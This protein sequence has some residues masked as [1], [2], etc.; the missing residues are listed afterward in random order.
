M[1]IAKS[2]RQR[3]DGTQSRRVAFLCAIKKMLQSEG[4][5]NY[6]SDIS[7]LIRINFWRRFLGNDLLRKFFGSTGYYGNSELILRYGLSSA[8]VFPKMKIIRGIEQDTELCDIEGILVPIPTNSQYREMFFC[9]VDDFVTP[10]LANRCSKKIDPIFEPIPIEGPYEY[11]EHVKLQKGDIVLDCGANIGLFSALASSIGCQSYAFEPVPHIIDKYLSVTAKHNPGITIC[12]YASWDKETELEFE[13]AD[14]NL[15][16]GTGVRQRFSNSGGKISVKAIPLD[17]FVEHNHIEKIDF[18]KADIEG[19]ERQML[20]GARAILRKFAPK[21][22]ICTYHL[23][24]DP[25]ILA[26]IILD[27]NPDYVIHQEKMKLFAYV[28]DSE[29]NALSKR[30]EKPGFSV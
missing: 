20:T 25:K 24:D 21:L 23:P 26:D 2:I 19:A 22:S 8:T 6:I 16:A 1:K 10:F 4:K 14:H 3:F 30:V 5:S 13:L 7:G 27:A 18:I 9:E 15:G 17:T 28:P 12:N 11:G 29:K